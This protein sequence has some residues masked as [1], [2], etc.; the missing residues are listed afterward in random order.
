MIVIVDYGMGNLRSVQKAGQFLGKRLCVT[1]SASAIKKAKKIIFPGVGHFGQA[2]K[3]LKR[4]KIFDVLAERIKGGIPFLGICLGMQLLLDESEEAPHIKGLAV[5]R[6]KVKRFKSKGLIV[7]QMGW[8]NIKIKNQKLKTE[9]ENIFR[10]IKDKSM[11]YFAQSYYCDPKDKSVVSTTTDYGIEYAS[12]L[13]KDN[14][15]A[16][17]FHPEKSQNLG[18]KVFNNFLKI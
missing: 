6:G 18:L 10:G 15:W 8:N 11:F 2:V 7:P 1:S 17:Q 3:E 12:S 4:R 5:L 14:I 13:H 16:V 9:K